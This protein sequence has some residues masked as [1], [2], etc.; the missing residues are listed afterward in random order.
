VRRWAA[1][2]AP[3]GVRAETYRQVGEVYARRG[4]HD[5]ANQAQGI[6]KEL[7]DR[8]RRD[9]AAA[10]DSGQ[11][12]AP[13]LGRP[14]PRPAALE[15]PP[16]SHQAPAIDPTLPAAADQ[17][18]TTAPAPADSRGAVPR[19]TDRPSA[20]PASSPSNPA[21]AW[22]VS[23]L[24][25]G[26][27]A[28]AR[29]VGPTVGSPVELAPASGEA[30]NGLDAGLEAVWRVRGAQTPSVQPVTFGPR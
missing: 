23:G 13:D 24:D 15:E 18:R 21:A 26:A 1:D 30:A 10:P 16:G 22:D 11:A 2:R 19:A 25:I 29:S 6:S 3:D 14:P 28:L 8:I 17:E 12:R 5:R 27:A 7:Q 4:L 9:R 20:V